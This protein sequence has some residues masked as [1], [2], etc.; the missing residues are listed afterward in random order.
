M[1]ETWNMSADKGK[2]FSA[3]LTDLLKAFDC[4]NNELITVKSNAYGL[5]IPALQLINSYLSNRKLRA[6]IEN[7]YSTWFDIMTGVRK[8]SILG[9]LLF[10]VFWQ[11]CFLL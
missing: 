8:G 6:K 2:V 7:T 10:N 3:L 4:L 9:P 1:S 5:R 11:I